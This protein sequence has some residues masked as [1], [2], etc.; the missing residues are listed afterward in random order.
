MNHQAR[1]PLSK[2]N[3]K[4]SGK[5]FADEDALARRCNRF[6]EVVTEFRVSGRRIIREREYCNVISRR[7][8]LPEAVQQKVRTIESRQY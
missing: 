1:V 5:R 7:C 8:Q 4:R 6:A 3:G 2:Q